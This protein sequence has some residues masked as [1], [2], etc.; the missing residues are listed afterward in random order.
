MVDDDESVREALPPLL[1]SH[2]FDTVAFASAED[3]LSSDSLGRAS[4]LVLD[5]AMPG[6]TG[7]ELQQILKSRN[8]QVPIVFITARSV[9]D[10]SVT[11]RPS[12]SRKRAS[13]PGLS[14]EMP[15][16]V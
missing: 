16:T 9:S 3:Y 15:S 2:G 4:C 1:R 14:G 10:R 11:V 7:P 13:F 12:F 8:I 6:T 5:V